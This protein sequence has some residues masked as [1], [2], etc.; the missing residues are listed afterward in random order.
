AAGEEVAR[1]GLAEVVDLG[2]TIYPDGGHRG[3]AAIAGRSVG[4]IAVQDAHA[5]PG[6]EGA[7]RQIA[8]RREHEVVRREPQL[9]AGVGREPDDRPDTG[10]DD[11]RGAPEHDALAVER[12][13]AR[14]GADELGD[15]HRAAALDPDARVAGDARVRRLDRA[16]ARSRVDVI[17]P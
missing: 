5:L 8:A 3:P 1:G 14:G 17:D 7:G 15:R 13:D 6:L 2:F 16:K 4:V 11:L 12:G 9:A 10:R